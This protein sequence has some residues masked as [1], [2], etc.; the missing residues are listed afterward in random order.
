M[1]HTFFQICFVLP[2]DVCFGE[3][4]WF[5]Y[6]THRE[7]HYICAHAHTPTNTHTHRYTGTEM[8]CFQMYDRVG[9]SPHSD[10]TSE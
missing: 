5:D 9:L 3:W 1:S 10:T 6:D 7:T 4:K 8:M 2:A